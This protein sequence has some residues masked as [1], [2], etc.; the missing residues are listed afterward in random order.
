M[1]KFYDPAH[2]WI[3]TLFKIHQPASSSPLKDM[4]RVEKFATYF[5][6]FDH[7][8]EPPYIPLQPPSRRNDPPLLVVSK[9]KPPKDRNDGNEKSKQSSESLTD[10]QKTF[11]SEYRSS[12]QSHIVDIDGNEKRKI[13]T[14][15]S[16][17]MLGV[18]SSSQPQPTSNQILP[19]SHQQDF[20]NS[21]ISTG[22]QQ[23]FTNSIDNDFSQSNSQGNAS[24]LDI[25]SEVPFSSQPSNVGGSE[26]H[27][28]SSLIMSYDNLAPLTDFNF[29]AELM[30]GE[31]A[32]NPE[33]S[34]LFPEHLDWML[35]DT[36]S[37][38]WSLSGESMQC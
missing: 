22:P 7:V 23:D 34:L 14:A 12:L 6:R 25:T 4:P 3:E 37:N 18:G 8:K 28:I 11:L 1:R 26:S 16:G 38:D 24:S 35:C 2:I 15:A 21:Q 13:D 20:N 27:T 5:S 36:P 10:A 29:S 31:R 9:D 33:S 30:A 32:F 17:K 19:Q